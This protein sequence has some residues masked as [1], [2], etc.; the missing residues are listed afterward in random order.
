MIN[1]NAARVGKCAK[2]ACLP[3]TLART[4]CVFVVTF[5]SCRISE[6]TAKTWNARFSP[7]EISQPAGG[8]R[9]GRRLRAW[10][11]STYESFIVALDNRDYFISGDAS[12]AHKRICVLHHT[13]LDFLDGSL[14][15]RQVCALA[16]R[17]LFLAAVA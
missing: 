13:G 17:N 6:R 10:L 2:I 11:S 3:L 5:F 15:T 4:V 9:G 14:C 1:E 7:R 16:N 12:L 8:Q